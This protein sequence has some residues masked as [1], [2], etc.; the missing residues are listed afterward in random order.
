MTVRSCARSAATILMII[1]ATGC[2]HRTTAPKP[3][4]SLRELFQRPV[5]DT[6]QAISL[7]QALVKES[8]ST[9]TWNQLGLLYDEIGDLSAGEKAFRE[10]VALNGPSEDLHNN[11]GYNLF[12]QKRWEAAEAEFRKALE[13]NA[14]SVIVRNNLGALLARRGDLQ[15]A[16]KLFQVN[17]DAA[18]AHNNLAVVLFEAGMY[19]QSRDQLIKALAIRPDFAPALSNFKLVQQVLDKRGF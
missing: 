5:Q 8:P 19:E 7:L 16:L 14:N 10:A 6:R 17:G 2:L 11:L 1:V 3:D 12:L 18:A 13:V 9:A 15:G 4:A